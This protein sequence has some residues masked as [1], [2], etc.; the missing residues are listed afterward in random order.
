MS[1]YSAITPKMIKQVV[2]IANL[3]GASDKQQARWLEE[4]DNNA[5]IEKVLNFIEKRV[6]E[7]DR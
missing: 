4:R 1:D 2:G 5:L 3:L 7:K 6:R